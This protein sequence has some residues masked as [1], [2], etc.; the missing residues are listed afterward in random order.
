MK[1]LLIMCG[2]VLLVG[3][4]EVDNFVNDVKS[5]TGLLDRTVTLYANDGH[6]IKTWK[7]NNLIEYKGPV[8]GFVDTQ[9]L[10]VRV[11]GTF[12]VEGK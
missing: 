3:C 11:S 9:G 10:N 2:V 5:S 8:A 12:I 6:V 1:K 7:T 4:G